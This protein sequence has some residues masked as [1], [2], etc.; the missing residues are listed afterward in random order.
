MVRGAGR[1]VMRWVC[2]RVVAIEWL[3]SESGRA[4]TRVDSRWGVCRVLWP[5][6]SGLRGWGLAGGLLVDP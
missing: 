1:D 2:N 3:P 6:I 5:G 4:T